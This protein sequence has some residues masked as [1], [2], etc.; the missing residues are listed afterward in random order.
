MIED[1]VDGWREAI[2][3]GLASPDLFGGVPTR[4]F[5][6][7]AAPSI[8]FSALLRSWVLFAISVG[9]YA[10]A[11]ALTRWDPFWPGALWDFLRTPDTL[12]P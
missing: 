6:L 7:L 5:C 3:D 2:N 11:T 4:F 9:V 8:G 12:D 1:D 10:T